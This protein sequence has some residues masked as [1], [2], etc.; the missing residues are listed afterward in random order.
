MP[1]WLSG[2]KTYAA[3]LI[4]AFVAANGVLNWVSPEMQTTVLS[5]AAALGL[6]GL[7]D[8]AGRIEGKLDAEETRR[9]L[10]RKDMP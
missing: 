7:R 8:V 9:Y 4:A 10:S 5:I 1:A 2:W 3:A 6:W